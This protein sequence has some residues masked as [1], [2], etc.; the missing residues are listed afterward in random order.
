MITAYNPNRMNNIIL[1]KRKII[2][3]ISRL[4]P[5][6]ALDTLLVNDEGFSRNSAGIF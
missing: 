1:M 4:L 3:K 5:K 6:S 2:N